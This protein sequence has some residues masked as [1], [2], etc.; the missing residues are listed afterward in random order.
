MRHWN[1]R[2]DL[3]LLERF[4]TALRQSKLLEPGGPIPGDPVEMQGLT[5][6]TVTQC[7][8]F[9]LPTMVVSSITGSH[10]FDDATLRR[11]D[12]SKS[13][14]DFSVWNNCHFCNVSFDSAKMLNVR[15]FGCTFHDCSFRSTALQNASFSVGRNGAETELV[16]TVF[17]KG[18]LRGASCNNPVLRAVRF[19]NCKFGQFVFDSPLCDQVDFVGKYEELTF[20][21]TPREPARNNLRI[22]LSKADVFWL[23]ADHGLD[24][25]WV[26]LPADGSCM[27][28][29]DR[30][31][32]V[33]ILACRVETGGD[34]PAKKVANLLR[35]VY[36]DRGISPLEAGQ[37][38]FVI[39]RRMV[40]YF[41][42]NPGPKRV[43]ELFDK[44]R[45]IA[46][47]EGLLAKSPA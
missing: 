13:R 42:D 47:A 33:E 41:A 36:S 27:V 39:S 31:R 10:T 5:F 11:V 7:E 43:A 40:E 30:V 19:V 1:T 2:E 44:L 38:T 16:N 46:Q 8:E 15:F 29:T 21:G 32:A 17:E 22:D 37:T 23:H 18:D 14:L 4:V 9:A 3:Q 20:R 6:P 34:E 24:L 45:S 25:T 12:L 28:I 35:S 26:K